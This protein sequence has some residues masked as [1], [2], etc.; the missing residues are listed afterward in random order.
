MENGLVNIRYVSERE[1][2]NLRFFSGPGFGEKFRRL[3]FGLRRREREKGRR[4]EA[5][6][7]EKDKK[8][9]RK[10]GGEKEPRRD[11]EGRERVKEQKERAD[12]LKRNAWELY[13][14]ARRL[15]REISHC[16]TTYTRG[17]Y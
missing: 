9:E 5:K 4:D 15:V 6:Y 12:L 3:R 14:V 1:A 8:G 13:H 2:W 16:E 11:R 10:D 7:N 17:T